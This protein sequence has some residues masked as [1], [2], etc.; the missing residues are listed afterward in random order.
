M[1][2]GS[3]ARSASPTAH[4]HRNRGAD[5]CRREAVKHS[6]LRGEKQNEVAPYRL[7]AAYAVGYAVYGSNRA[8]SRVRVRRGRAGRSG[9]H[10]PLYTFRP[11]SDT[12]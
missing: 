6:P 1:G 11:R 8:R 4:R 3:C 9:Q 12:I 7:P 10:K 2:H 5:R